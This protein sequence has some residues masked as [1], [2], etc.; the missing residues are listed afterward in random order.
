MI[1]KRRDE[2]AQQF[3]AI[4][5][6]SIVYPDRQLIFEKGKIYD[7]VEG[8]DLPLLENVGIKDK[9]LTNVTE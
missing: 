1:A 5:D 3:V 8:M 4:M 7:I 9:E 2:Q 6:G